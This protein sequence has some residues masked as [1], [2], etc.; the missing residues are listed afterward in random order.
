VRGRHRRPGEKAT[1]LAQK[2]GQLQPFI[3]AFPQGCTGQLASLGANLTP[4]SLQLLDKTACEAIVT[5]SPADAAATQACA[6]A[7]VVSTITVSYSLDNT[8]CPENIHRYPMSPTK[9]GV[10]SVYIGQ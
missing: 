2:L 10:P 9:F 1:Q 7:P 6:Y 3:A 4:F 5:A 8:V